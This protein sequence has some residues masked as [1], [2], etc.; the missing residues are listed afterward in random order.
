M[1]R[2]L[3]SHCSAT[4]GAFGE[5]PRDFSN[6]SVRVT[7][8]TLARS[9]CGPT[10]RITILSYHAVYATAK[11]TTNRSIKGPGLIMASEAPLDGQITHVETMVQSASYNYSLSCDMWMMTK[12]SMIRVYTIGGCI[13]NL[14]HA[15]K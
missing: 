10:A 3:T 11:V 15:S 12:I 6:Q 8:T 2:I 1:R 5:G 14:L 7:W 13:H 9:V 4:R